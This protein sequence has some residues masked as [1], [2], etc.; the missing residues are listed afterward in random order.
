M[1]LL[2]LSVTK[3]VPFQLVMLPSSYLSRCT[4]PLSLPDPVRKHTHLK[5]L[6]QHLKALFEREKLQTSSVSE[7]CSTEQEC[8][9]ASSVNSFPWYRLL[10]AFSHFSSGNTPEV[11]ALNIKPSFSSHICLSSRVRNTHRSPGHWQNLLSKN[12][13]VYEQAGGQAEP[14]SVTALPGDTSPLNG[15]LMQPRG[16]PLAVSPAAFHEQKGI[17]PP[18]ANVLTWHQFY[19]QFPLLFDLRKAIIAQE[20]S[21]L[22]LSSW[23]KLSLPLSPSCTAATC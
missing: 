8:Y 16:K 22:C 11:G 2:T 18:A 5:G 15:S 21:T 3:P 10:N 6:C 9:F 23:G 19:S 17:P 7:P 1:H 12:K 14:P 13:I 4:K 20:I